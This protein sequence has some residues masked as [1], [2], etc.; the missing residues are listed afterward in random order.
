[1]LIKRIFFGGWRRFRK[2]TFI[3]LNVFLTMTIFLLREFF[4]GFENSNNYLKRVSQSSIIPILRMKGAN[5]GPKCNIQSGITI[6]NCRDYKRLTIGTNCHIGKNSFLDL[7]DTINIGNNVVIAMNNS[8]ITHIDMN[9]SN[10]REIYRA[11]QAPLIIKD[12]A[13]L[14]TNCTVLM[15]V[16]IGE[17]AVIGANSLVKKDVLQ[18]T[19]YAGVPAVKIRSIDGV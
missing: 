3:P 7:R 19:I 18:K 6:H 4:L 8:L 15:G 13:Y 10:L 14:G 11:A 2:Y 17:K 5:I 16:T 12:D 9:N 1:M